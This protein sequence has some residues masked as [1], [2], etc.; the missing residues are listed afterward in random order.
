MHTII[1]PQSPSRRVRPSAD[2][3]DTFRSPIYDCQAQGDALKLVVYLPGVEASGVSIEA[4]GPDLLITG[5]K[6]RF[7][8]VNWE[9]LHLEK[10]QRDYRLKLRLGR[11]IAYEAMAAEI[12]Q[13]VL[14]LVLPKRSAGS[15]R[16]AA[17][18][19]RVA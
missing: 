1:H 11:S 2:A 6:T 17:R 14:T 12:H 16:P 15:A 9:A 7:V 3:A 18:W 13:G 5:Q 19:P 8:R 4:L 10:S